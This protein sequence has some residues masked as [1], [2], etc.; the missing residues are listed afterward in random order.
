MSET[1]RWGNRFYE[2]TI[3]LEPFFAVTSLVDRQS[4]RTLLATRPGVLAADRRQ[5]SGSQL[6]GRKCSG[7]T[8]ELSWRMEGVRLTRRL[9]FYDDAPAFRW[10]DEY[11]TEREYSGLY[12]STLVNAQLQGGIGDARLVNWFSCSDQ[13]N[14]RE[15][16]SIPQAGKNVGAYFFTDELFLYKEG[17]MPDS[18][19][20]PGEYDFLYDPDAATVEMVGLG[21]DNLRP[22]EVRRANGVVIGLVRDFGLQRYNLARYAGYPA[23]REAS[24]VLSNSWPDLEFGISEAAIE[25]ELHAAAKSG[26]TVVFIDDG[27]FETYM[28]AIDKTKFPGGFARLAEIARNYGIE[29]GLWCNPLN[30]DT[31]DP[32]MT[33]WSGFDHKDLVTEP[34]EFNWLARSNDYAYSYLTGPTGSHVSYAVADLMV[35]ECFHYMKN[36]VTG[37]FRNYGIRHFKFDSY[38]LAVQNS[39]LGD[40]NLHYEEYRR[41]CAELQREIPDLVISFDVT[42]NDRPNFNFALDYGRLFLEN[43][44][45][46]LPDFRY[47][48]PYMALGNTWYTMKYVRACQ[49]ETEFMAQA[50]DYELDYILGTTLFSVPLYWGCLDNTP[51]DRQAAMKLF[52]EKMLPYRQ[53]FAFNLNIPLGQMPEKGNWSAILSQAPDGA[54]AYLAVYRNGAVSDRYEFDVPWEGDKAE[55]IYGDASAEIAAGRLK[56]V[57]PGTFSFALFRLV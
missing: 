39:R 37:M 48:H 33:L 24:S 10:Y 29:I 9:F 42:R 27:W 16:E 3:E 26:V 55:T 7:N 30:L 57:L 35:E 54:E 13:S 51:P 23:G 6:T 47:Y 21:F 44:G 28:G 4:G 38:Q 32:H 50:L 2:V 53:K 36:L 56:A 20:I 25:K 1:I 14:H 41:L 5:L 18:Q 40:A 52:F 19:P 8:Y 34:A 11:E 43:R 46:S 22:G 31:K 17:P 49:L 45:R 12:N 15:L